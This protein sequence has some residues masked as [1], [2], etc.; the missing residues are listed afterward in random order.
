MD[1]KQ[2]QRLAL[3]TMADQQ[4]IHDR[5]CLIGPKATQLDGAIRGLMDEVGELASAAKKWLEYGQLLDVNN[6]IEECGDALWRIAQVLDA[7]GW[8]VETAMNAN[9][10]KLQRRYPVKYEDELAAESGRQRED[11]AR[12]VRSFLDSETGAD[13]NPNANWAAH[14]AP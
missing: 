1:A 7:V 8:D 3:R 5:M 10:A 9:I 11:E 2:Y 4:T 14:G 6:V 12:A 13:D